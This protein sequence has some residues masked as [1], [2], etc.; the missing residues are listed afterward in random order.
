[1]QTDIDD[2]KSSISG[3]SD[4]VE[5]ISETTIPAIEDEIATITETTIPEIQDDVSDLDDRVT[6]LEGKG[7]EWILFNGNDWSQFSD[8]NGNANQELMLVFNLRPEFTIDGT[9]YPC[10]YFTLN[11]IICK[12]TRFNS[13][14]VGGSIEN[15]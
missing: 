8:E 14:G 10:G 1:M 4:D 5:T 3:I 12:G 9:V 7:N 15:P 6:T 13:R 2:V 11:M